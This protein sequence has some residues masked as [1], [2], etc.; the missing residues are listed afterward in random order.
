[1]PKPSAYPALV[2]PVCSPTSRVTQK[3]IVLESSGFS[4]S[5]FKV[6][7]VSEALASP[8]NTQH[9]CAG[10]SPKDRFS[11][12]G[13]GVG[14]IGWLARKFDAQG[15]FYVVV[16]VRG[17]ASLAA[18][19]AAQLLTLPGNGYDAQTRNKLLSMVSTC[20]PPCRSGFWPRG[21]WAAARGLG[22]RSVCIVSVSSCWAVSSV[23]ASCSPTQAAH[24]KSGLLR[25]L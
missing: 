19:C 16:H 11:W 10:R 24:K 15:G 2:Q 6:F 18:L 12:Q 17:L 3:G 20:M 13:D 21:W 8:S 7:A 9:G 1:M 22:R 25:P 4:W 5:L 14:G 23:C